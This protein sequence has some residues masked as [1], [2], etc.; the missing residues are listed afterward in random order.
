MSLPQTQQ[1]STQE[2]IPFTPSQY[3]LSFL[4]EFCNTIQNISAH[5]VKRSIIQFFI[6]QISNEV[7]KCFH[8]YVD[9]KNSHIE[10]TTHD[11]GMDTLPF[12]DFALPQPLNTG[13]LSLLPSSCLRC[14]RI[15]RFLA[16]TTLLPQGC[17]PSPNTNPSTPPTF[18]SAFKFSVPKLICFW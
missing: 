14:S 18:F 8:K 13:H 10:Q 2:Q 3:I 7:V 6:C 1:D 16:K 12:V 4:M 17:W 15:G 5:T 9:Q 11:L